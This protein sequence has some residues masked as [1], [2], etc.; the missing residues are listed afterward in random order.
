MTVGDQDDR[1]PVL[2]VA[3]RFGGLAHGVGERRLALGIEAVDRRRD[4]ALGAGGGRNDL[5]DI[6]TD[7]LAAVAIGDQ[8]EFQVV[9]NGGQHTRQGFAG[10]L[11]L[12]LAVDLP[13]HGT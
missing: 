13:P 1:R 4:R 2:G 7:A 8:A 11:D 12:G 9:G 5:L 10:D 6:G 3:Q